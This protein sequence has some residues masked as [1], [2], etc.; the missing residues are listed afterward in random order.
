MCV[1]V[2]PIPKAKYLTGRTKTA[3]LEEAM[4]FALEPSEPVKVAKAEEDVDAS[5]QAEAEE[6]DD[7]A[8]FLQ[9][10]GKQNRLHA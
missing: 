4:K 7:H 2:S 3:S 9:R 6:E 5:V 1:Q 10:H 8:V